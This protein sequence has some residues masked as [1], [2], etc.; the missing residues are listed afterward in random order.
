MLT[1]TYNNAHSD[2]AVAWAITMIKAAKEYSVR[3][4][5]QDSW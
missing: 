1:I 5:L 2:R 4:A 3:N